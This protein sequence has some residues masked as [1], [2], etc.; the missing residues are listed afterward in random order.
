MYSLAS[1]ESRSRRRAMMRAGDMVDFMVSVLE[2]GW[3]ERASLIVVWSGGSF[4]GEMRSTLSNE[5]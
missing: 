4:D 2:V 5:I 1:E 3:V